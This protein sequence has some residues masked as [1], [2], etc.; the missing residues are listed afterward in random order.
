MKNKGIVIFLIILAAVIVTVVTLDYNSSKPGELPSNPYEL[1]VDPFAR[2]DSALI[3]YRESLDF[4]ISFT[5]PTGI[6]YNNAK[7]YVVGDQKMQ[8]IEPTG[9]LLKEIAFDMKPACVY[10]SSKNIFVGFRKSVIILNLEGRKIAECNTFSDSTVITS[11]SEKSDIIFVADAGKRLIRKFDS[12]GKPMGVI[13]GKSG[14]DQIHG[15]IIPSPYF[16]L[17]FNSDGELWVVNPGKHS[18]ENY[19]ANGDLRTWWKATSV[20]FEGFSGCCN[21]AHFAFLPDGSFVT[22]EKGTIRIKVYKAS[23]EF[24]GV[25]AAPSRFRD[26]THAPDLAVDNQGNIYA[27]DIDRKMLRLF[28]KKENR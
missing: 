22:S 17:A 2:V 4:A 8:I 15:F 14:N 27:L 7:I 5:E 23:G 11:I 1:N 16:D 13:A 10:A 26:N 18:L 24:L 3:I 20:R 25:V 9:K 6:C 21:P 12:S 28:V 19:T